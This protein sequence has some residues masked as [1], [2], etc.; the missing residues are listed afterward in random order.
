MPQ[1]NRLGKIIMESSKLSSKCYICEKDFSQ[2]DL[3][4]HYLQCYQKHHCEICDNVFQTENQ[5]ENHKA[6]HDEMNKDH[7]KIRQTDTIHYGHIEHKYDSCDK[8]IVKYLINRWHIFV[9]S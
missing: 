6:V 9:F 4:A 2:Y 3:K 8:Q 1:Y 5:L 7:L